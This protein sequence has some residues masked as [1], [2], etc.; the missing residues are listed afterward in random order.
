MV[1]DSFPKSDS[2]TAD[3]WRMLFSAVQDTSK[4]ARQGVKILSR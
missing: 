4:W 3:D 2:L 1:K